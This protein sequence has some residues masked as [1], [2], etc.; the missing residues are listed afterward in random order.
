MKIKTSLNR[1]SGVKEKPTE[2]KRARRKPATNQKARLSMRNR[3]AITFRFLGKVF[4]PAILAIL[5]IM[6]G[7]FA[8][9]SGMFDL[10]DIQISGCRHQDAGTL[11]NIIRE[12]FPANVLRINL[13]AAVRRLEKETWVKRVEIHRVLPSSLALRIEEREPTVLLELGGAQMMADSEGVLLGK[14]KREFGKIESP[15]FRG[16]AGKDPKAYETHYNE[17]AGRIRR[18]VAMLTEI[19][20]EMPR[21]VRNISEIDL[22]ELNNIKIMLDNDQVEIC[23]GSENYLKR[24]SGFVGDPTNKYQELKNQ[25]VQVAQIDLSND[26]QIVYKSLEAIAREKTLKLNRSVNR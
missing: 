17:N 2:K 5:V 15:I 7:I 20:A 4:V 11:E 25:G 24:F 3:I 14:Y 16:L 8:L 10:S 21:D 9:S 22:S 1:E 12:E 23:M 26:G 6:S 13:V 19:A 18:G